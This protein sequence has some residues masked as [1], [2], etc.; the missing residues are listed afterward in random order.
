MVPALPTPVARLGAALGLFQT[1]GLP[2]HWNR[3]PSAAWWEPI[4]RTA[5]RGLGQLVDE[6]LGPRPITAGEYAGSLPVSLPVAEAR[7]WDAGFVRN[8]FARLKTRDGVP[9]RASWVHRDRP[10]ARRQLHLMLFPNAD[11][12]TDVYAHAEPSSVNP[13]LAGAHLDGV[14]QNVREGVERARECLALR[15]DDVTTA[16]PDGPWHTGLD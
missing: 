11:E 3:G 16:A 14:G 5:S 10:L 15:T 9:E 8:P 12:G 6:R 1:Y 13:L 4:R 7:L 2:F